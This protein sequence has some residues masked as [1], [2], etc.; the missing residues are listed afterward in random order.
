MK[1]LITSQESSVIS[2]ALSALSCLSASG[3]WKDSP[4]T[5]N[6]SAYIVNAL[7]SPVHCNGNGDSS[8]DDDDDDGNDDDGNDDDDDDDDDDNDHDNDHDNDDGG[9][10]DDDKNDDDGDDGV[11]DDDND[12]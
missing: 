8:G 7:N 9:G 11:V 1:R 5:D 10:V 2:L 4:F 6:I 12:W 3:Y